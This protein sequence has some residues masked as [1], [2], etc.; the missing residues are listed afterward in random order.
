MNIHVWTRHLINLSILS[1]AAT[2]ANA[3]GTGTLEEK[4]RVADSRF[5]NVAMATAEGY[6]PIPCASG[7]TG[8]AMGI[9]YVNAAYL[10]DDRVDLARPEAVMYEP[11]ADGTQKLVAV[12]YITSK[13][14]ASL[15]GQLFNF[16][17]APNRYGLGPFYELHVWAWKKNPTGTFAD[18]NPDVSC[19]AMKMGD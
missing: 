16:N 18:M 9:H 12:E 8:G 11:M 7:I 3:N 10:K 15:E 1:I 5:E 2:T 4:V 19:E 6:A 13:G 14:P 17:S